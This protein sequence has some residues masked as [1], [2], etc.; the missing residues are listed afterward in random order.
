MVDSKAAFCIGISGVFN[1]DMGEN[2]EFS[3]G[4]SAEL[5]EMRGDSAGPFDNGPPV[6]LVEIMDIWHIGAL[7]LNEIFG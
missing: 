1:G 2:A 4:D 6:K 7:G 3:R 5:N